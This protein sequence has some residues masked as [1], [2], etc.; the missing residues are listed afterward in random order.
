MRSS[1]E[2]AALDIVFSLRKRSESRRPRANG[3]HFATVWDVVVW[4]IYIFKHGFPYTHYGFKLD[5]N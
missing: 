3:G 1:V 4:H 5:F 2:C